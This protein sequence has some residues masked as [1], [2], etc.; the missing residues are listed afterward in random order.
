MRNEDPVW[1]LV[2]NH[3]ADF[4]AFADR[5]WDMPELGFL[6]TRSAA[7]HVAMLRK[8][9]FRVTEGV[10]GLPTAMVG[11]AGDEGPVIAILGEFD[12]LPGLSNEAGV[13]EH[14]PTGGAGHACGHNLLGAA[15]MLA[16]VAVKEWLEANGVKG[17]VRYY[18]CPAEENGA[19]KLFMVR[20]GAFA[21]AWGGQPWRSRFDL[22]S[23]FEDERAEPHDLRK[24]F[25]RCGHQ[26]RVCVRFARG[27]RLPARL[28]RDRR[29]HSVG[30]GA[31]PHTV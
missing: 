5:V 3:R 17:R 29:E 21:C 7:E 15:S 6:E 4:E 19:G 23:Q 14:R 12:A 10:A 25:R 24:Q 22:P 11:E 30:A 31:N 18:G 9:G 13:A 27:D 28:A 20:D 1:R 2:E 16:A 26:V 8:K